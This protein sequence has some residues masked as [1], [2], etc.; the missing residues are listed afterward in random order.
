MG[1]PGWFSRGRTESDRFDDAVNASPGARPDEFAEELAL[2]GALRELGQAGSPDLATRTRIRTEIESRIGEPLPRRHWRPRMADLVAAGIA[3]FLGL[4]GLTLLLSR[5]AVPGDALYQVKRAGE[6]TSL[7]LT[8]GDAAKAER[9]LEF[10]ANRVADL[11]RMDEAS[12]AAY[13]V[14]LTDFSSD[15]RA[16]VAGLTELATK[17]SDHAR[18]AALQSWAQ[19]QSS[20]LQA[21]EPAIPAEARD[22]FQRAQSLLSRVQ[23]RTTALGS[24]L[25]CYRITTGTT[26]ELGLLPAHGACT[27]QPVTP[28]SLPTPDSP[29]PSV[30]ATGSPLPLHSV[31]SPN[32]GTPG[33]SAPTRLPTSTSV[34]HP[35]A[36]PTVPAP[37]PAPTAP[38]IPSQPPPPP[39][40]SVPPVLPG[41]PPIVVG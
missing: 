36:P 37:I 28:P 6:V 23:Q 7:G 41:L 14:A 25:N 17:S 12:P 30:P 26:D 35:A 8:F 27:Q 31:S 33:T 21:E 1:V 22:G 13:Q 18:L 29:A 3:L 38:R 4:T 32:L 15:L 9:H 16:G 11:G 39:V 19:T 10:A 20:A 40:I 24:R 5:D 34:P 2:V